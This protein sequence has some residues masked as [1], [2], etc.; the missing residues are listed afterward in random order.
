MVISQFTFYLYALIF[1]LVGG[2]IGAWLTRILLRY[3]FGRNPLTGKGALIGRTGTVVNKKPNLLR[4]AVNSQ[5]W[6]AEATDMASIENG[7]S[8]MIQDVDNLTLKVSPL[9][10]P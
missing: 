5:V 2:A 6:N 4:V 8:V 1:M 7:D 10:K 3:P 9:K